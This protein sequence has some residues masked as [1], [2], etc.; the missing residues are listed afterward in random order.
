MKLSNGRVGWNS[1][2]ADGL[3]HRYPLVVARR[4]PDPEA[5]SELTF[6][7]PLVHRCLPTEA[8]GHGSL[9]RP[10]SKKMEKSL[11]RTPVLVELSAISKRARCCGCTCSADESWSQGL[12]SPLII[13]SPPRLSLL[14]LWQE[15]CSAIVWVKNSNFCM[16][17]SDQSYS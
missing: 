14:A 4:V 13:S 5:N 10:C 2:M 6:R 17:M 9:G 3:L 8:S 1:S 7:A 11:R 15:K 16:V 12:M